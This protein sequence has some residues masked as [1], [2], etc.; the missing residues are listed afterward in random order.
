MV[1][2]NSAGLYTILHSPPI[3]V[4]NTPPEI[5][6]VQLDTVAQEDVRYVTGAEAQLQLQWQ[7]QDPET[8]VNHCEY[9]FGK[10]NIGLLY[11]KSNKLVNI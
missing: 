4:D 7:V 11:G 1:A 2:E 5:C 6:C 3:T 9:G 10:L 8:G